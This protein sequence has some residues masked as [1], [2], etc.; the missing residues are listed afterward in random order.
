MATFKEVHYT[1]QMHQNYGIIFRCV[2]FVMHLPQDG[3]EWPKH[4][5]GI[6]PYHIISYHIISYH[7]ISYHI[8]SHHI[9]S[10]HII[11]FISV[12]PYRIRHPYRYGKW[13]HNHRVYNTIKTIF[14]SLAPY[15][16]FDILR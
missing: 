4:V 1:G 3:P 14:I 11:S 15:K 12:D 16:L 5:G 10:H 9:I 6:V 2:Y 13:S 7:I 8:I